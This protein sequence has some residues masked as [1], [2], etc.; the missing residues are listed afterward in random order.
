MVDEGSGG[1]EDE[2]LPACKVNLHVN[3]VCEGRQGKET[4]QTKNPRL[5]GVS[6]PVP[7]SQGSCVAALVAHTPDIAE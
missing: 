6:F 1:C 5:S 4:L 2:S 7:S 3:L